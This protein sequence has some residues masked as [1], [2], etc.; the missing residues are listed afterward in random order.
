M[1]LKYNQ[2][3]DIHAYFRNEAFDT[4]YDAFMTYMNTLQHFEDLL[5]D[6]L[7]ESGPAEGRTPQQ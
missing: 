2:D 3:G 1:S 5:V 7:R 4:P 6:R